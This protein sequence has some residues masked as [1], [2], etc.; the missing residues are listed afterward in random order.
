MLRFTAFEPIEK[1]WSGDRK[2]RAWT[3][4]GKS[5]LVRVTP[6]EKGESRFEAFR[7]QEQL[8]ALGVPMCR[9]VA[10]DR[11]AEGIRAVYEWTDGRDAEEV[12]PG[13]S[14]ESQYR[15]GLEAGEI[16][17]LVHSLPAPES[18]PPWEERY[19]AKIDRK[20]AAYRACPVRLPG[21]EAMLRC[22]AE[23]RASL[24]GRPQTFQHGDYHTG[25]MMIDA[26]GRL[27]V[28][29]FDRCDWGDPWEEFNRVVWCAQLSGAFAS[30]M[31][32]GY[33]G[34]EPPREFW[35]LLA[36]YICVNAVSSIPWAVPFGEDEVKTMLRQAQDVLRWYRDLQTAIPG[37]YARR[38]M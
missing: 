11:C 6:G 10:I 4:D 37:W 17:R 21:D 33:F 19:G 32:E 34:G 36:L 30:G 14:E 16:L 29:D 28:I 1:G 27:V 13:L 23:N 20:I 38:N 22:I 5:C 7:L 31:V 18:L 25:N 26:A 15:Y 3:A 35:R 8:A 12:L 24:R 9:P 2:F